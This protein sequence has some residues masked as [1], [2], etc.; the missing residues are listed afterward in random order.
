MFIDYEPTPQEVDHI[1]SD[2]YFFKVEQDMRIM[3]KKR[4][5]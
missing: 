3:H 4:A 1:Y 5:C 2:D